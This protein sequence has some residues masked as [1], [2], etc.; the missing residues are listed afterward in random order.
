[1]NLNI[2]RPKVLPL[3]Y[4]AFLFFRVFFTG[5]FTITVYK[6]CDGGNTAEPPNAVG[7]A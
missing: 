7:P 5:D 4:I 1:M 6:V 2:M 3:R